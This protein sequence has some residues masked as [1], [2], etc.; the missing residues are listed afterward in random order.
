MIEEIR[1]LWCRPHA[2]GARRAYRRKTKTAFAGNADRAVDLL[3]GVEVDETEPQHLM[4][5]AII[6]TLMTMAWRI[7][8]LQSQLI[9]AEIRHDLA[10]R[11]R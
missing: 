3:T 11:L 2:L 9:S 4:H 1:T 7:I 10:P 6:P 5:V 8:P